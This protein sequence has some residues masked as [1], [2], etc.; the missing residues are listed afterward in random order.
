[1]LNNT[2]RLLKERTEP[3]AR[4]PVNS[5]KYKTMT[6]EGASVVRKVGDP[7]WRRSVRGV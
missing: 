3:G 1:M 5:I 6:D 4:K 7:D 2:D